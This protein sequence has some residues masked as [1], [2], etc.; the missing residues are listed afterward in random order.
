MRT[1]KLTERIELLRR[2]AFRYPYVK[3]FPYQTK[4]HINAYQFN[5]VK[6]LLDTAY[7][8]CP[9]YRVKYDAVG[10]H[11]QDITTWEHF[12]QIPP[13][14]KDEVIDHIEGLVDQRI[15][16]S[17]LFLSRSSG[18]SGRFVNVYLDANTLIEQELHVIRML[19]DFY[20][21]YGPLDKEIL[22]YTSEM[23]F[24]NVAGMYQT[25]FVHNMLPADAI[26]ERVLDID[27][28]IIAIYPSILR[29]LSNR[30]AEELRQRGWKAIVT[31]SEQSSQ[32]ER[33][34]LEEI[35]GCPVFDEFSSEEVPGIAHQCR[36]KRYH[37]T[38]DSCVIEIVEPGKNTHCAPGEV[39]EIIGTNLLNFAMPFIRYRQGDFASLPNETCECGSNFP[40]LDNLLGR[41]NSSFLTPNQERIPSGR[42]LDWTYGLVLQH[43]LDIQEFQLTQHSLNNI[44]FKV[45]PGSHYSVDHDSILIQK[46][47][48]ASFGET[49][50]VDVTISDA[51]AKGETGKHIP[52]KSFV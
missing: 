16:R 36:H 10:L 14:T 23:P 7:T 35:I 48:A 20:P 52:I 18:S 33:D 24:T 38:Q 30:Y 32:L 3:R 27:A 47:F 43:E 34:Q 5:R 22:V 37:V 51:I 13:L 40:V 9:Y 2:Y 19:T 44:E 49:F 12:Y 31:N 39:G 29:E 21:Q 15:D 41:L 50:N 45:I 46:S 4:E 1:L 26:L 11:P 42:L 17:Q 8:Y 25:Y 28:A 6:K